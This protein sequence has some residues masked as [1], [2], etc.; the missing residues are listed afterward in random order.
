MCNIAVFGSLS[1]YNIFLFGMLQENEKV[2]AA[3]F[4]NGKRRI[5]KTFILVRT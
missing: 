2:V 4:L 5:G 3:I 1:F